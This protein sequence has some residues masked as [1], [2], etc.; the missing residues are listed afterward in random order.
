MSAYL[1]VWEKEKWRGI[2]MWQESS[3]LAKIILQ[4][5]CSMVL[6]YGRWDGKIKYWIGKDYLSQNRREHIPTEIDNRWFS[7]SSVVPVQPSPPGNM[8]LMIMMMN[9]EKNAYHRDF[10]PEI[11]FLK[12]FDSKNKAQPVHFVLYIDPQPSRQSRDAPV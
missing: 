5:T 6:P 3:G 12:S 1:A 10:S 2:D 7:E 8:R 11:I 4:V 9:P